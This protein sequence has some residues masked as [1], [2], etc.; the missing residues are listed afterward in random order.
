MAT[1]QDFDSKVKSVKLSFTHVP[2]EIPMTHLNGN[3]WRA[4][5]TDKQLQKLA[6][7]GQTMNYEAYVMASDKDGK[8][9]A[10]PKAVTIS[11]K[12]PDLSANG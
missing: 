4:E 1:V 9:S 8:M 11:V 12:A 7:E 6:V 3:I 10:S 5:L 2:L